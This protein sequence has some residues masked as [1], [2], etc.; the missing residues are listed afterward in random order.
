MD[1]QELLDRKGNSVVTVNEDSSLPDAAKVLTKNGIGSAIVT[2]DS[3][4]M[5]GILSER[6][7][8]RSVGEHAAALLDKRVRDVMTRK[9]VSCK[10]SDDVADVVSSMTVNGIRHVPVLDNGAVVGVVSIRDTAALWLDSVRG[11]G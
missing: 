11:K 8:S 7:I 6:D 5:A 1:V 4:K 10:P 2:E 9:V 3:G